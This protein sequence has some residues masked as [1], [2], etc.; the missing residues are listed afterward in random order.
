[1]KKIF[2]FLL[3]L[4]AA[5]A[6]AGCAVKDNGRQPSDTVDEKTEEEKQ[7]DFMYVYINGKKLTVELENNSSVAALIAL[8]EKQDIVY[9]ADDYGGFEKVGYIGFN[10]PAN[11]APTHTQAG[12]VILYQGNNICLYYGENYWTFTR[13]GRIKG[14]SQSEIKD[15]LSAGNGK[16]TVTLSL[17]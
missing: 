4:F 6:F 2:I 5:F 1:M 13:I 16:I 7:S 12:D 14:Y 11:D 9:S 10:L 3:A 17:K 8:L 15:L